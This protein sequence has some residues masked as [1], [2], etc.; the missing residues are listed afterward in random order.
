MLVNYAVKYMGCFDD[1]SDAA[2]HVKTMKGNGIT[3]CF[4]HVAQCITFHQT[5]I[6]TAT[7]ISEASLKSFY[8]RLGFKVIND[9]ATPPN[10]KEARKRF[11]YETEKSKALQKTIGLQ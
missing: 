8:S 4:L 6:V 3:K 1:Y 9:F 5:N 10:F 2:P 7:L 11:N